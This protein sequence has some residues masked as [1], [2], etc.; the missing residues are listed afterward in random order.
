[1]HG[2]HHPRRPLVLALALG[3]LAG[4]PA[5]GAADP[6]APPVPAPA[7][8]PP[9]PPAPGPPARCPKPE[10]IVLDAARPSDPNRIEVSSDGAQVDE[11]GNAELT[12][13]VRV[14]QGDRYLE[15]EDAHYDAGK[16]SFDVAGDVSF[17]DPTLRLKGRSGTWSSAG[18]GTFGGASFE[19]P[20]RPA[21]GTADVITL[22]PDGRLGLDHVQF[23]SCPVGNR[24]WLLR[25]KTIDIDQKKQEGTARD[26]TLALKGVPILYSPVISF[27]VGDARK[28]GFLFPAFSQSSRSGFELEAPWYWNIA[29]NYDATLTPGILTTRGARLGS[30]FRFLS[31]S[32]RGQFNGDWLPY[33]RKEGKDRSFLQFVD[34]T[35]FTNRLRFDT[36]LANASDARYF[37]DFGLGPERTSTLFLERVARLTYLDQH[38]RAIGLV[39]QFQTI[40]LALAKEDRPYERLPQLLVRGRWGGADGPGFEFRGE[41]V[42]FQ[43]DAG[44][45]GS[46]FDVEPTASWAFR[47]PGA[48]LVPA[49]GFRATGWSLSSDATG[50]RNPTRTAPVATLDAGMVLER[51]A[52]TRVQTLEPRILYTYIPYR[53]QSQLPNF[54]TGLPDLNLIQLFRPERYVGGDRLGDANQVAVGATTR[55]VDVASGRQLLSATLG[56]IYYFQPPRVQL[57]GENLPTTNSSD[58]IA[59]LAITAFGR[60]TVQL[61]EQWDPHASRSTRSNFR[62]WYDAGRGRT[63]SL[64][65]RFRR[66]LLEQVDGSFTWPIKDGWNLYGSH[67]YSLRDGQPIGSFLGFEYQACCWRVRVLGRRYVSSRTGREDTGISLQLELNGLSNVSESASAFLERAVRGYSTTGAGSP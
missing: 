59:Q 5:V 10:P 21:R 33:D 52:G 40:D 60:W 55:L 65:Y 66:D 14:R 13:K 42:Y 64:G 3:A 27:P 67:T 53:D 9:P 38:W 6:A 16:Q 58:I 26:V 1:L 48:F 17:Q 4:S 28:T 2:L 44:V 31:E 7:A 19:I 63:V 61:A 29:P 18:G 49:L 36:S 8:A 24:D 41:G 15:A 32:S 56:Q 35:D 51:D 12:G 25:A 30:E 34:R 47:R 20:S 37:E 39:Q 50:N 45:T 57:P 22:A 23:T 62:V 54:D 46:R 43:R 11:A